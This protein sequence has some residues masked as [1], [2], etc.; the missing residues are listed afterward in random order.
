[1]LAPPRISCSY[2]Q[3]LLMGKE[4]AKEVRAFNLG[5]FLRR[6]YEQLYDQYMQELRKV[7]RT[8]LL[9]T[10]GSTGLAVVLSVR[11]ADR[12]HALKHGQVIEHGSHSQLMAEGG[13]YAELFTLQA[14]AYLNTPD[15]LRRWRRRLLGWGKRGASRHL[16]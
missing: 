15:G 1:M 12:I 7:T 10:V 14:S 11:A 8:R 6:V 3:M 16:S 4:T 5:G 2:L 9:R 13:L